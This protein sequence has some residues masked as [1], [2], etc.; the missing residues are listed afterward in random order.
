MRTIT[1]LAAFRDVIVM[2]EMAELF[3]IRA[4]HGTSP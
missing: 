4:L 3:Q 2:H 1:S